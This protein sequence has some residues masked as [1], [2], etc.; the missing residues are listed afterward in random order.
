MASHTQKRR[1]VDGDEHDLRFLDPAGAVVY[2][3]A[4]GPARHDRTGFVLD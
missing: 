4:K 3:K 2:L 1:V